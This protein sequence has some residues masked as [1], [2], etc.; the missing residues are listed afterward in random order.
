MKDIIIGFGI[1]LIVISCHA[2]SWSYNKG[3]DVFDGE[4]RTSSVTGMSDKYPWDSP[5]FVVNYLPNSGYNIYISRVGFF[6][7]NVKIKIT[8]DNTDVVYYANVIPSNKQE[9]VFIKG[10]YYLDNELGR[11]DMSIFLLLDLIKRHNKMYIRLSDD[12]SIMNMEFPL[13]GSSRAINFVYGEQAAEIDKRV[14]FVSGRERVKFVSG[15]AI[16]KVTGKYAVIWKSLDIGGDIAIKLT[17]SDTVEVISR[18]GNYFQVI[19]NDS[20]TGWCNHGFI[21]PLY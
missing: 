16:L 21:E 20:I 14:K 13:S 6:C 11:V 18:K 12:C 10:A 1:T 3:R 4:Y 2:Q 15:R 17:E 9:V 8:F 5:R 19:I 7:D